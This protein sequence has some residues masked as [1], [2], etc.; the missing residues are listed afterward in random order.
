MKLSPGEG[1]CV[2]GLPSGP[3]RHSQRFVGDG[4]LAL[5]GSIG[6]GKGGRNPH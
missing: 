2:A 3:G 4:L 5:G 1:R 6:V